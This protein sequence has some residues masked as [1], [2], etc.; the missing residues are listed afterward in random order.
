MCA[1]TSPPEELTEPGEAAAVATTPQQL[2]F[3]RAGWVAVAALCMAL[4]I[5]AIPMRWAELTRLV[6]ATN[7]PH[8]GTLTLAPAMYVVS[9]CVLELLGPLVFCILALL[10]LW[11]RRDA[12]EAIR[13]SAVL[14]AFGAALPGTAY[15]I[16]SVTPI[17][18][19]MPGALQAIGW[20]ALLI[21]AYLFPDGRWV[22]RWSRLLAP[23]WALWTTSFFALA[24]RFLAG[25]P[26]LIAVSYLIWV[27]WLGTGVCAQI[28]RY[29]RVATPLQRQQSKWVL[30]GFICALLGLLGVSAQ[31][32]LTLAQGSAIRS[33]ALAITL[34]L[35]IILLSS[36]PIPASIAIAI[37]RH[38]LY[39]IDRLINLTLVYGGLTFTLGTLYAAAVGLSQLVMRVIT[40]QQNE[41]QL[42]LVL[43]TLGTVALFHP[44][45]RR[46]Q[47]AIDRRFYR[48]RYDAATTIE[49]FAA[50]LR[51]ELDLT[52]LS[53]RLVDVTYRTMKPRHISLWLAHPTPRPTGVRPGADEPIAQWP[54]RPAQANAEAGPR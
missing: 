10:I 20:T 39:D 23:L 14:I 28:Y 37:L 32:V 7:A 2:S 21:F 19:V 13:I 25:H 26:A 52:E 51:T 30:L 22:P 9:A 6:A 36:L 16:I 1:V 40:G 38:N 46:I 8:L 54:R 24:E 44:L 49:A 50:S 29:M 17:W 41:T 11:R 47:T 43:S 33:S 18:R 4:F 45:R 42:A 15:A 34:S 12:V 53:Q 31:Q 27:G 5:T 35:V 48:K 3:T